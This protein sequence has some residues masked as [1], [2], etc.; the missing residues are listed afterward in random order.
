MAR[1][2]DK[3]LRKVMEMRTDSTEFIGSLNALSTFYG[4]GSGSVGDNGRGGGGRG[5]DGSTE[6]SNS[7]VN[8]DDGNSLEA[9]R[10]LR[11]DLESRSL[12]LARRFLNSFG[13]IKLV[14]ARRD[15]GEGG[16][17]HFRLGGR[18]PVNMA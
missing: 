9:R 17:L 2:L 18:A 11:S 13:G 15:C 8:G 6:A 7:S 3:K 14:R 16:Y 5:V 10:G 12:A 4:Q 1:I